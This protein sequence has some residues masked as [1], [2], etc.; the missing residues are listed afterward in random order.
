MLML[1]FKCDRL[2]KS[3]SGIFNFLLKECYAHKNL[4]AE[5]YLEKLMDIIRINDFL[6]FYI[7]KIYIL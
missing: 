6:L 1:E 2:I 5:S 7:I 4:A 3:F